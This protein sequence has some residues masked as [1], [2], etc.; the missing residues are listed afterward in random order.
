MPDLTLLDVIARDGDAEVAA[1]RDAAEREA[2]TIRAATEAELA[3]AVRVRLAE[4]ASQLESDAQRELA[5]SRR[6]AHRRILEA[7]EQAIERIMTA[8]IAL[9][10][11]ALD[12][13]QAGAVMSALLDEAWP[14]LP[15]GEVVVRCPPNMVD[16]VRTLVQSRPHVDVTADPHIMAGIRVES[17]DRRVRVD[18]TLEGRLERLRPDAA[19]DLVAAIE[20]GQSEDPS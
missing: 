20:R 19:A 15:P 1:I 16:L 8:T 10:P 13:S 5:E 7:R 12:E 3:E 6:R 18:N 14:Y 2:T 17:A 11:A 9:L 4:R